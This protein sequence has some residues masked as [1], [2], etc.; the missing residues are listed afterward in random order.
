MLIKLCLSL[1]FE[2][3]I[4]LA[5][6]ASLLKLSLHINNNR[7][8]WWISMQTSFVKFLKHFFLLYDL[9]LYLSGLL[10]I[11]VLNN[12][13]CSDMTWLQYSDRWYFKQT[14]K[15]RKKLFFWFNQFYFVLL[16]RLSW[17][18]CDSHDWV[19]ITAQTL[20]GFVGLVQS[21]KLNYFSNYFFFFI[22]DSKFT[23]LLL[24]LLLMLKFSHAL[25]CHAVR[26]QT[27]VCLRAAQSHL[28]LG[29]L[30]IHFFF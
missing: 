11:I 17:E 20:Q 2:L 30:Q 9:L 4:N 1:A 14:L 24:L 10:L 29:F 21:L 5:W 25:N 15:T 23:Y 26:I 7:L 19:L 6:L 12:L 22:V 3:N 8:R 28:R 18:Y 27:P 16:R 13:I